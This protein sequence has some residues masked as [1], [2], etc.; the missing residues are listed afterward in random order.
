MHY[1]VAKNAI[2]ISVLYLTLSI[3]KFTMESEGLR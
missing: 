3:V 2:L 1:S